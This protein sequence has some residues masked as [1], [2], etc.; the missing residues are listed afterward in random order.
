MMLKVVKN[1][2][3]LMAP[4]DKYRFLEKKILDK[5]LRYIA[6]ITIAS[7]L[8]ISSSTLQRHRL[9]I[10][11]GGAFNKE[12]LEYLLGYG[13]DIKEAR[14]MVSMHTYEVYSVL[15]SLEAIGITKKQAD[16][17]QALY[18]MPIKEAFIV[19]GLSMGD[20]EP[21]K[22]ELQTCG[23]CGRHLLMVTEGACTSCKHTIHSFLGFRRY[24]FEIPITKENFKFYEKRSE[25]PVRILYED[26]VIEK[27]G[28]MLKAHHEGYTVEKSLVLP[29]EILTY[30]KKI[31]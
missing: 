22:K 17:L 23:I 7:I 29:L 11:A 9:V 30:A 2:G 24:P 27:E 1:I 28:E 13:V 26:W 16:N 21:V 18:P 15:V 5:D 20:K 19:L 4:T 14:G 31:K 25:A 8:R 6:V 3:A 12:D 10:T